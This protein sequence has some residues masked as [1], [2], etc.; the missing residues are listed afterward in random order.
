MSVNNETENKNVLQP[1]VG[2][3]AL[4]NKRILFGLNALLMLIYVFKHKEGIVFGA[5][6][7]LILLTYFRVFKGSEDTPAVSELPT[8]ILLDTVFMIV[9]YVKEL[10]QFWQ[11]DNIH[12][13]FHNASSPLFVGTSTASLFLWIFSRAKG[14]FRWMTGVAAAIY[15]TG[16]VLL[17]W[18]N[19]KFPGTDF[20]S[21]GGVILFVF[22]IACVLWI[23]LDYFIVKTVPSRASGTGTIGLLLF[24][25]FNVMLVYEQTYV[26]SLLPD[27]SRYIRGDLPSLFAWW[28]VILVSIVLL[29]GIIWLYIDEG[30]TSDSLSIDTYALIVILELVLGTK[31]LMANYSPYGL[32]VLLLLIAGTMLCMKN[33]YREKDTFRLHH[34]DYLIVQAIAAVF[35]MIMVKNGLWFNILL[36]LLFGITIYRMVGYSDFTKNNIFWYVLMIGIAGETVA[37]LAHYKNSNDSLIMIAMIFAVAFAAMLIINLKQPGGRRSSDTL[38]KIICGCLAVLCLASMLKN[39]TKIKTKISDDNNYVIAEVNPVGKKNSVKEAYYTWSN[40]SGEVTW[41]ETKLSSG[42]NQIMV[43]DEVL[44]IVAKDSKGVVTTKKIWYPFVLL[45]KIL[46]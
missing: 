23:I 33:D 21:Y 7:A 16:M 1:F 11:A 22:I 43:M 4:L 25:F 8:L 37:W 28:K 12:Y 14:Q 15:G 3:S 31:L 27:L 34:T 10:E 45:K 46:S 38:R 18:S 29:A 32:V 39:G 35:A 2:T 6:A 36:T 42:E 17:G 13:Y 30:V 44:T 19:M 41:D 5:F 9:P 24:V 20:S 40:L 26:S